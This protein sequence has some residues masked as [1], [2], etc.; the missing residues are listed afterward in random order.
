MSKDEVMQMCQKYE[1]PV[2]DTQIQN[3]Q[4]LINFMNKE[5]RKLKEPTKRVKK[6][7]PE[8]NISKAK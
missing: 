1:L 3:I 8:L 4:T 5:D 7:E 6:A 2:V